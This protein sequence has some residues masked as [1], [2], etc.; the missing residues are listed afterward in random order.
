MGLEW[1]GRGM[2]SNERHNEEL[3]TQCN[4]EMRPLLECGVVREGCSGK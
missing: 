1:A 4:S 2:Q 3:R